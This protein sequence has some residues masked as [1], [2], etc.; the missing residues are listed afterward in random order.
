MDL[1]HLDLS[2]R[3]DRELVRHSLG[4]LLAQ[5]VYDTTLITVRQ[6]TPI[7]F[8]PQMIIL[9]PRAYLFDRCFSIR[10]LDLYLIVQICSIERGREEDCSGWIS[11]YIVSFLSHPI[12]DG[13]LTSTVTNW[14]HPQNLE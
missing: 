12:M 7:A 4:I 6:R 8:H 2:P 3:P 1:S 9:D 11:S 14:R 10:R 5:A 13:R